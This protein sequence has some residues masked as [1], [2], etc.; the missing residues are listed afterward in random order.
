MVEFDKAEL[1]VFR[2]SAPVDSEGR[3]SIGS[4]YAGESVTIAASVDRSEDGT[5]E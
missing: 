1:D 4:E 5:D 2:K 3:V